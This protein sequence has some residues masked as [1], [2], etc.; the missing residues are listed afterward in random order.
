M[1]SGVNS[2]PAEGQEVPVLRKGPQ[3]RDGPLDG[4]P[5]L[6]APR[7]PEPDPFGQPLKGRQPAAVRAEARVPA[8]GDQRP[9]RRPRLR[10][11]DLEATLDVAAADDVLAVRA[12]GATLHVAPRRPRGVRGQR[13]G[14]RGGTALIDQKD[15]VPAGGHGH[16]PPARAGRPAAAVGV[17]RQLR[18]RPEPPRPAALVLPGRPAL[19]AVEAAGQQAPVF[20]EDQRGQALEPLPG[21]EGGPLLPALEV[22]QGQPVPGLGGDQAAVGSHD[23]ILVVE[24]RRGRRAGRRAPD[25][26][27]ALPPRRD[28]QHPQPVPGKLAG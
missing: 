28:P 11:P 3:R 10:V 21:R 12:Q 15:M 1:R 8:L 24:L 16:A 7:F 14:A 13:Q 19:E 18:R 17:I 5:R 9:Q 22:N 27:P 4:R 6:P 25:H 20:Q 2:R 26:P 23:G